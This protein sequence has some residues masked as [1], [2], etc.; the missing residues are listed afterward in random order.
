M[1]T[2]VSYSYILEAKNTDLGVKDIPPNEKIGS[3]I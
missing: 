3:S 2:V 1:Y